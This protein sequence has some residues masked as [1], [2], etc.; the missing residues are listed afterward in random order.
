MGEE[1]GF[2]EERRKGQR[3]GGGRKWEGISK[4]GEAVG[5]DKVMGNVC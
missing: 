2:T 4:S 3:K 1:G 5:R